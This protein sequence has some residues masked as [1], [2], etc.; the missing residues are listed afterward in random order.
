MLKLLAGTALGTGV[1]GLSGCISGG[2][3]TDRKVVVL[4]LDGLDPQILRR[5]MDAGRAP[6][7]SVLARMGS[8]STLQT[9]MPAL[10]PVA[11]SSFITGLTPGGHGIADFIVRDPVSYTPI[12]SIYETEAP[13]TVLSVGDLR[14]PLSGGDVRNLRRGRPFWAYLTERG[15]PAMVSKM[16]TDFPVDDTATCAISGLGTPDLVDTYGSFSYY[17]SDPFEHYPDL[18]GGNVFYVDVIDNV[19]RSELLGPRDSFHASERGNS[20]P[21]GD[22]AKLPLRVF[23]DPESEVVRIDVQGRSVVLNR[24]EFSDWVEVR[25]DLLPPLASVSGIARFYLKEV[26]P[27]FK[28]FV[29]PINIDPRDQAMDV[30]HPRDLGASLAREIGPFWTKGLPAD[31][32]ALDHHVL[33]EEAYV[34]EAELIL[35]ERIALFDAMWSRYRSGLFFFYVSNTDQDAHML[36]RNADESHPCHGE[37]DRRFSGYIH[38]LYAEIDSLVGRVL[39][40]VDDGALVLVCSDHGFAPFGRRFHLNGW[41]RRSG[42]LVPKPAAK[43]KEEITIRDVD[44]TRSIAYGIGF[45][46]LYLNLQGREGQGI[47]PP[48]DAPRLAAR[49]TRDLESITDPETGDRPVARVYPRDSL[50]RGEMT[51]LMP[52][53]LVG[54][55]RGYRCAGSSVLGSAGEQ[56]L[57]V[58]PWAWSGDHA[59]AHE[60]VPGTLLSSRPV[61]KRMPHILDLPV[62]IL[63]LFGIHRP[64]TMDG[65]SI[66]RA[67]PP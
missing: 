6:N 11:W 48:E 8:F 16:P 62:T 31:T 44:W 59:M 22:H 45:N 19:V 25:F 5:V 28:L 13:S 55:N 1:G 60:L 33:S 21:D 41:L 52:E 24:G 64:A 67:G 34:K 46:G 56:V 20:D 2:S 36:W 65:R 4:G 3:T 57:D 63:E 10:S 18:A 35:R 26:R 7:F 37:S 50:Y 40:A 43:R 15:I 23:L 29:T 58:N 54:Y 32:K 61:L 27:H 51:S 38:D 30:T 42:Y 49:L 17:T 9:T 66:F 12:F 39:P 14:L 53:L 47:V